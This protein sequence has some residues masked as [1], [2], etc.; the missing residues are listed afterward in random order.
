VPVELR[1]VF[2]FLASKKFGNIGT[3]N[4]K[5]LSDFFFTISKVCPRIAA[6]KRKRIEKY[7]WRDF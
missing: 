5:F 7:I 1:P 3:V 6:T 2:S 4:M